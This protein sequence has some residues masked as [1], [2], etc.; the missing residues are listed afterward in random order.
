MVRTRFLALATAA[1]VLLSAT[2][3]AQQAYT[4]RTANV[5]AGPDT[6]FPVVAQLAP[7][8]PVYVDGCLSDYLWCDIDFG[9]GRG[10]IN[11]RALQSYY[12]SRVVPLYGYGATLGLPI[13]TFSLFNYWDRYYRDRPWYHDRPRWESRWGH[14]DRRGDNRDNRWDGRRDSDR[15]WDGNRDG[16]WDGRR[17]NDRR[18]ETRPQ[19]RPGLESR[20][21][22]PQQQFE[23][24]PQTR[25]G[26]ESR[27][28][29]TQQQFETRPQTRPG[30]DS[31]PPMTQQQFQQQREQQRPERAAAPR[32]PGQS[33]GAGDD[34]DSGRE[35]RRQ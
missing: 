28:P 17:D 25:P 15:R 23:T 27:P 5:R 6:D 4:T 8:T 29:M 26:L 18:V 34:R 3:W 31:R 19:T 30:L 20:P 32:Q 13:V 14:Y 10:W 21:P 2:A 22:M 16:R 12:G 1:G 35:Q 7:G 9:A 33:R 11:T 24:R